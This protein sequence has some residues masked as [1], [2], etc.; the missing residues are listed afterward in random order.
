MQDAQRPPS[1]RR[2]KELCLAQFQILDFYHPRPAV[3]NKLYLRDVYVFYS[4]S[5]SRSCSF[6][7]NRVAFLIGNLI[8]NNYKEYAV[9]LSRP[10]VLVKLYNLII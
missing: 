1:L 3:I 2:N 4:P 6:A 9:L 7:I 5:S 8:D 10:Q